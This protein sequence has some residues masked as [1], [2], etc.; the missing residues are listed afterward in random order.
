MTPE[1]SEIVRVRNI[2]LLEVS[3]IHVG[4]SSPKEMVSSCQSPRLFGTKWID[5]RGH[6][7]RYELGK[8]AEVLKPK[9]DR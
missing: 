7:R 8:C 3:Q 4:G 9:I 1:H 2:S 5:V 6:K